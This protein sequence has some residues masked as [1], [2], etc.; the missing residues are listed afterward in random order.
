MSLTC[1]GG[2]LPDGGVHIFTHAVGIKNEGKGWGLAA[3]KSGHFT[4]LSLSPLI[5]RLEHRLM[6]LIVIY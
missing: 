2:V 1:N 5:S 4:I 3:E 6:S